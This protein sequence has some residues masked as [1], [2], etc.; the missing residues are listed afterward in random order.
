VSIGSSHAA[1]GVRVRFE[2]PDDI[3]A[4]RGVNEAAFETD[5]EARI[6]DRLRWAGAVVLSM[7]AVLGAEEI[8][9]PGPGEAVPAT[10]SAWGGEGDWAS[11]SDEREELPPRRVVGGQVVGHALVTPVKVVTESGELPLLGLGPVA[12]HPEFQGQGIGTLLVEACLEHLREAGHAGVVVLGN[13]VY[14]ARF[15]FIPADRWG[16]CCRLPAPE[17]HFM[18]LELSPGKLAGIS[19]TVVYRE[20]FTETAGL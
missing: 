8:E 9:S 15:G 2:E 6:V 7:V 14:Y 1:S 17:E 10:V 19:G 5:E 18:V 12:V 3:P 13:P 16:L 4:I 11:Q 20:E